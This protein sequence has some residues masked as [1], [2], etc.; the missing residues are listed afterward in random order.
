MPLAE[1]TI[2]EDTTTE[3]KEALIKNVTDTICSTLGKD[4]SVV[5]VVLRE[6]PREN[7]GVAG[8]NLVK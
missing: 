3:E 1:I 7:Y 5:T 4:P 6:S 8:K 2:L